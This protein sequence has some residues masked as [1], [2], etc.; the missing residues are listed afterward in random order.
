[1]R[2]EVCYRSKDLLNGDW[3]EQVIYQ[4]GAGNNS[5]GLAQ[6]GLVQATEG[7]WYGFLFQ[8]R[9]GIGRVPSIVAVQWQEDWPMMGTC[10]LNGNFLANESDMAMRSTL[11]DSGTEM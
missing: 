1:M 10:A 4:G 9:G 8:D 11:A 7:D 5:A 6:G 2:T 3:E